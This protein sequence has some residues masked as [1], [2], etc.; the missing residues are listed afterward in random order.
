MKSRTAALALA[1]VLFSSCAGDDESIGVEDICDGS[2]GPNLGF[3]TRYTSDTETPEELFFGENGRVFFYLDGQCRA[4]ARLPVDTPNYPAIWSPVRTKQFTFQEARDLL[5]ATSWKKWGRL[6]GRTFSTEGSNVEARF[7]HRDVN[8]TL[9]GYDDQHGRPDLREIRAAVL[10]AT[11]DVAANGEDVRGDIRALVRRGDFLQDKYPAFPDRRTW[12]TAA[13]T[14]AQIAAHT[15]GY[16][17]GCTGQSTLLTGLDAQKFWGFA[18]AYRNAQGYPLA[19][20]LPV[21][22]EDEAYRL[23]IR[24]ALPFEDVSSGLVPYGPE[25]GCP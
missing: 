20:Y 14:P 25:G 8:F 1:F 12:P 7:F 23:W 17:A 5:V 10:E 16:D 19:T 24:E 9:N 18:D 2:T 11:R 13:V 4:W 22:H 15:T 21:E 3:W 6:N